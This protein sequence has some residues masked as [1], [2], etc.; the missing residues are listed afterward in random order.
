MQANQITFGVEFEITLPVAVEI[1]VGGYHRGT[2]VAWLPAGWNAQNDSSISASAGYRAVEVVSPVLMGEAGIAQVVAVLALLREKGAKINPS[3][4]VHVHVG[5][6][7]DAAA[8]ARLVTI[9]A[10]FEK[11]IYASTGTKSREAGSFCRSI[12]RHGSAAAAESQAKDVRYHVLNLTNIARGTRPAVEFRAFAGTLNTEKVLGHI[13][14]CLGLVQRALLAARKTNFV[15][16][17][18]VETSPIARGG[19]GQTALNRLFYQLG[20]TKGRTPTTFGVIEAEGVN[21][22]RIKAKLMEMAAKYDGPA[23]E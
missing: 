4:G 6:A 9:V 10:N 1:A 19:E 17:K 22:K 2:Q 18:P 3:C 7:G 20:W 12:A 15:A 14:T 11:A 16:K 23:A 21:L 13:F 5:F 8:M